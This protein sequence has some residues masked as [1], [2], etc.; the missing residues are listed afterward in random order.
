VLTAPDGRHHLIRHALEVRHESWLGDEALA[1]LHEHEI[2]LVTADTAG[3]FPKS[4]HR[5]APFAY[6]R[7]HGAEQLYASRYTNAELDHWAALAGGWLGHGSDVYVYF[8]NDNKA[9]APG[10][11][12]RLCER[13]QGGAHAEHEGH[14]RGVQ[15]SDSLRP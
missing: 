7:L 8:D 2:A 15:R 9:Y 11:A 4:I 13:L 6:V 5:T 12:L 3:K 10:D 14:H 1:L